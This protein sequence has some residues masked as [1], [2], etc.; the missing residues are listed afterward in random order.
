MFIYVAFAG[1]SPE[2][3]SCEMRDK[4]I[5]MRI[6]VKAWIMVVNMAIQTDRLDRGGMC[7]GWL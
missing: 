4:K 2:V 7:S 6:R 3:Y 1:L 5:A